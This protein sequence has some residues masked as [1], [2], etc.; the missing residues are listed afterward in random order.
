M[1]KMKRW[2]EK[3]D[4]IDNLG[5]GGNADVYLVADKQDGKQYALKELRNRTDEKKIRFLSEIHIA[6]ENSQSIS[7][8]IPVLDCDREQYWY[9]MPIAVA[10]MEFIDN[11][12]IEEII[13]GVI[14]LAETLG[15]LHDKQIYHRD[16]KPSN[17]YYYEGR[18]SFGDFGLVDFPDNPDLTPSDRG[19]GAIFTI[20]P[21][22]KRN[23]KMADAS[24]AD[25]YS[26]AK[27]LWMFLS[28]DEKGFDGVYNYLDR[29]HSLRYIPRYKDVHLVELDQLIQDSTENIPD[30]RPDIHQ[31]KERLRMWMDIYNDKDKSQNSDWI[32]L[33]KQIFRE[34]V[35]SSAIWRNCK[36][37]INVLNIIGATPAYNHMLFSDIGGLDFE[38]CESAPEKD[39]I[40]IYDTLG[41][42]FLVKPKSLSFEG[43][44]DDFRWSYFLLELNE[45]NPIIEKY[46][47]V[48]YEYLVEDSPGH[49]VNAKDAGYG[50]YDYDTGEKLPEGFKIVR[51]YLGGKFL[52]VL[53]SGPYNGIT[54]TYDGRHGMC[55]RE[56]FREYI[57]ELRDAYVDMYKIVKADKRFSGRSEEEVE[58]IILHQKVFNNNPFRSEEK[59]SAN[60]MEE[61]EERNLLIKERDVYVEKNC[62]DWN[63]TDAVRLHPD[64]CNSKTKFMFKLNLSENI[65]RRFIDG[66]ELVLSKQGFFRKDIKEEDTYY[67]YTID[68]A[69]KTCDR[70]NVIFNH[71][72]EEAGYSSLHIYHE[73]FSVELIK[74]G[75]PSHLFTKDEIESQMRA[76]DDR[77]DNVLV[78]DGDG[79]ARVMRYDET[80]FLYPVRH[81]SWNAGNNYV[82]KYSSL[83][84]LADD[85]ICSLQGWLEYLTYGRRVYMDYVRENNDEEHLLNEI[86][87]FY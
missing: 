50:V 77:V 3:Y 66:E 18:F 86:K 85:Y 16:I 53:K 48:G 52:I 67:E 56:Q 84:S 59:E 31:F 49:Y 72:I 81:E 26:L 62:G 9:T 64:N 57:E 73:Y 45:M 14:Q 61:V 41:M 1:A 58:R 13:E 40:Y 71:N 23:P 5:E 24:K 65:W 37:I 69:I 75:K 43:F 80:S 20:A 17:I 55:D 11:R 10:A 51:R 7:G 44:D 28:G 27:T 33:T 2:L 46:D 30:L 78:I 15:E 12:D 25:V 34:N 83:A 87:K 22:M 74:N 47:R 82:G 29:S 6:E 19:V 38:C 42:C 35:P 60:D 54:G 36:E 8:I 39:C 32:F 63:Y 68:E 21:E 4:E 70:L 76:A 79:Y